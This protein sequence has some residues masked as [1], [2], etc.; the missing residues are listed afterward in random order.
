[1]HPEIEKLI[2]FALADGQIND[3]E[4]SVIL[5][6]AY[7]LGITEEEIFMIIDA[8]KHLKDK[9]TIGTQI[10]CPSC[11]N[12]LS[13]L[14]KTCSC[15]YL[16]N[17]GSIKESKSLE[18]A[19]ET[20]ENLIIEVR[21]LSSSTSKEIIEKLI[22]RVEKEIR[23]I[24]TRY[25]ENYEVKKLIVELENLSNK[26][27]KKAVNRKKTRTRI[28]ASF[29]ILV[30]VLYGY[31]FINSRI[32]DSEI[33]NQRSNFNQKLDS[34]SN[35]I[36]RENIK[37]LEY[38]YSNWDDFKIE[39]LDNYPD[40]NC[41]YKFYIKNKYNFSEQT[42]YKIAEYH[43]NK[44]KSDFKDPIDFI[45]FDDRQ[46]Y[47]LLPSSSAYDSTCILSLISA[48]RW[49]IKKE[50]DKTLELIQNNDLNA[51]LTS[52]N[53]L[54]SIKQDALIH[55][56]N[57]IKKFILLENCG[58]YPNKGWVKEIMKTYRTNETI[59]TKYCEDRLDFFVKKFNKP[60]DF[61]YY[62]DN[63]YYSDRYDNDDKKNIFF[64]ENKFKLNHK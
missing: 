28:V 8:K 63:A 13:G 32:I 40:L 9:E 62:R 37:S 45:L 57:D 55:W 21:G 2:D 44:I 3:N 10:K 30:I 39:F 58:M 16:F 38:R 59:A 26:Y 19:V 34:L 46:K 43:F 36:L 51:I 33:S 22:A 25:S 23:F 50:I 12:M 53:D 56:N 61:F 52:M 17:T 54:D 35:P 15:G 14:S 5:K 7:D 20:L 11:G 31:S 64:C 18:S 42:S 27:I 24:K 6:K 29:S 41:G 48:N 4:R 1:M 60:I 49:K 47:R